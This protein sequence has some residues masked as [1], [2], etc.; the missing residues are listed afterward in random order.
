MTTRDL[1]LAGLPDAGK[2]TFI[3]ALWFLV[4]SRQPGLA[5][6]F[7]S[8]EDVDMAYLDGLRTQWVQ[9][10]KLE[11]TKIGS[12]RTA[13]INLA[14]PDGSILRLSL[15]DFAGEGFRRMW[16]DRRVSSKIVEQARKSDRH[17]L[18]VNVGKVTYPQTADE[19][20]RQLAGL[21]PGKEAPFD[22]RKCPTAAQVTD[23]LQTLLSQSV[24]ASPAKI[25]VALTAW[26]E[27][28]EEGKTPAAV[29]IERLPLLSQYLA[30][31]ADRHEIRLYGL[32]C[33]GGSYDAP[34]E[35]SRVLELPPLDRLSLV[36]DDPKAPTK[37]LTRMLAW[38]LD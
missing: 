8:L 11:R 20:R 30:S 32:S 17:L 10:N 4:F 31:L 25:A 3:A 18:L 1:F 2:T 35:R 13:V 26:D 37:D 22:P 24:A 7:H 9:A 33:Q 34:A 36:E 29:L 14:A 23:V 16:A 12:E 5:L 6:G 38:L 27:V 28:A 19:F 21:E 15:E